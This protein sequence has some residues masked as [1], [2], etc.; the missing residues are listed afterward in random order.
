MS[1]CFGGG[2][3]FGEMCGCITGALIALGL[4]YGQCHDNDTESKNIANKMTI[5]FIE[6]FKKDNGFYLCK[7]LLKYD[8]SKKEDSEVII[9]NKLPQTICPKLV[10]S[11]VR[12]LEDMLQLNEA[13]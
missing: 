9:S 2:M 13:N 3:R 4:K 12:I 11:A 6:R 1:A 8:F 5:D 10:V 7:E